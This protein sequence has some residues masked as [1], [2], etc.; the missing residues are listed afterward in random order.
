MLPGGY[1]N[2]LI[3]RKKYMKYFATKLFILALFILVFCLSLTS[4][5]FAETFI[6]VSHSMDEQALQD[7]YKEAQ[8]YGAKLI[9]RGLINDS[10]LETKAALDKIEIAYDIDPEKFEK[11]GIKQ[12]PTIIK[13][14]NGNVQKISGNI[15]L[16]SALE[17]FNN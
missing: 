8:K 4:K 6:F 14:E 12:V 3:F 7:Y 5:T 17:I 9:V 10:F 2:N 13:D 11:Y 15:P 1:L 16:K